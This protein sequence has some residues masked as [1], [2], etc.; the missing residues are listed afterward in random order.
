MPN[1]SDSET[2]IPQV[3]VDFDPASVPTL[4]EKFGQLQRQFQQWFATLTT[5]AKIAVA[6]ILVFVTLS[7]LTKVLHL[8]ASLIGVAIMALLLYG[9]Y[10]LFLRPDSS[11]PPL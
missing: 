6:I 1:P 5:P 4:A 3:K 2:K 10:R 7:V 11:K 8:V 9:L